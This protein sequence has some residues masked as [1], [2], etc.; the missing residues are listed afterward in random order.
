MGYEIDREPG[1]VAAKDHHSVD[2][3]CQKACVYLYTGIV[4]HRTVRGDTFGGLDAVNAGGD[5]ETVKRDI[6]C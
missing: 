4:D 1:A 6:G 2:A 5:F 3:C